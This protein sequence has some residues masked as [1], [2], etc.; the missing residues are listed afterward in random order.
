MYHLPLLPGY[1]PGVN[2]RSSGAAQS[3]S[4]E[5]YIADLTEAEENGYEGKYFSAT[6]PVSSFEDNEG[7]FTGSPETTRKSPAALAE[8]LP[9]ATP[10]TG[11]SSQSKAEPPK[12]RKR[13]TSVYNRAEVVIFSYGVVVFF[14]LEEAHERAIL[15]D[16]ENAGM[17]SRKLRESEWE[18]EECHFEVRHTR[19]LTIRLTNIL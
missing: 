10:D 15:E 19:Y 14:G 12:H 16:L 3:P 5:S 1:V 7:Y 2:V 11:S 9:V 13:A 4:G 6:E 8:Q 18:V 17:L